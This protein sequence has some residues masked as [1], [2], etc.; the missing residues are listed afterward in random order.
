MDAHSQ[1]YLT[2]LCLIIIQFTAT[3]LKLNLIPK[4][5]RSF[6][7][8]P[9]Q[10]TVKI[11]SHLQQQRLQPLSF[12]VTEREEQLLI[13][14]YANSE[15]DDDDDDLD[16]L[17]AQNHGSGSGM[18]SKLSKGIIPI[19]ASMGFAMTPSPTMAVRIAGA[20][21]GGVAGFFA[22][23]AI[24]S[25][26]Q[27]A[28][29]DSDFNNNN[30]NIEIPASVSAGMKLLD[31]SNIAPVAMTLKDLEEI[32]KKAKI[33]SGDLTLFFTLTLTDVILDAVQ[34]QSMDLTELSE[35]FDF[36]SECSFNAAEIGDAFALAANK[37]GRQIPLDSRGLYSSEFDGEL[38]FYASKMF[39]LADKMIGSYEGFYGKRMLVSLSYFLKENYQEIISQACK[40]LF[41][42]CIETILLTPEDFN[43]NEITQ[44]K[45]FLKTSVTVSTLRPAN[46][47]NMIMEA[48]QFMLDKDF[49]ETNYAPMT[50]KV[51]NYNNFM[52]AQ[53]VLGWSS[54]E[55]IAT[56]ETKTMPLFDKV[57]EEL[58][59]QVQ[60][61]PE[62]AD[63]LKDIL[64]ERLES[65]NIDF[66]KA[67]I[68]LTNLISKVNQDYMDQLDKVYKATPDRIEPTFKLMV[69]YANTHEAFTKLTQNVFKDTKIPVPGLPFANKIRV[70]LYEMQQ[71]KQT[72][73]GAIHEMFSMS[74][75][76]KK[77][78]VK[79]MVL[80]KISSWISQC[81]KESNFSEDAK[82]AYQKLLK[83]YEANAEEWK[84]TAID[85]YY[86]E[87][88]K[89]ANARAVPSLEDINRLKELKNFLD[90]DENSVKR[91]N[92]E[93]FGD[94]YVKA[95][96]EAMTPS[97]IITE[98]YI[99]G[100]ARL[101]D[102]L[103]LSQEDTEKLLGVSART[104]LNPMV[105]DIVDIWKSN[106]DAKYRAE[107][108]QK[109]ST[110]SLPKKDKSLDPIDSSESIFGFMEMSA[111]KEVGGPNTFMR[112]IMNLVD[113][114]QENFEAQGIDISRR[115]E[116][117]ITAAGIVNESDLLGVFKYFLI[118]RLSE[119]DTELRKRYT[120]AEPIFAKI[121]GNYVIPYFLKGIP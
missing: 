101:R 42:R 19:A 79:N 78:I 115:E 54:R 113:I 56:V 69:H 45:E 71:E 88:L 108:E 21:A 8:I 74:E 118:T 46:M 36:I 20:A 58:I 40:D 43:N 51:N 23:K 9:V 35:V 82:I 66:F 50:S 85:F 120:D 114:V 112:E 65:L 28:I 83:Q 34:T 57:A 13:K 62:K 95:V 119:R 92:L 89:I 39:F 106:T 76:Q 4:I 15:N 26:I 70:M 93:L 102:R 10:S 81:L 53:Q 64:N 30:G 94:K 31:K 109:E 14:D 5:A 41:K 84:S 121:L 104:R 16:D 37:I 86:Q 47:Q 105:K 103:Q 29:A 18:L 72:N 75:S 67:K 49:Q 12:K 96:T 116:I 1:L 90:C 48:I 117:P 87:T 38:F 3:S 80:P 44:L 91:V 52:K 97:G 107:K 61:E 25:R 63:S 110:S 98:E 24:D 27:K 111:Q 22:K 73:S 11:A 60:D 7:N 100:L 59:S 33:S 77:L 32:A 68:V 2:L 55:M 99:E 17:L 6:H